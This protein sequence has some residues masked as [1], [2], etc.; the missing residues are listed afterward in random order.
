MLPSRSGPSPVSVRTDGSSRPAT[1]I[2][3][4][5]ADGTG[6]P[7]LSMPISTSRPSRT[8]VPRPSGAAVGVYRL[9]VPLPPPKRLWKESPTSS[10]SI[11][12]DGGR[13]S[14]RRYKEYIA[15]PPEQPHPQEKTAG[16]AV[17]LRNLALLTFILSMKDAGDALVRVA[18]SLGTGVPTIT[19]GMGTG[20]RDRLGLLRITVLPENNYYTSW[21]HPRM[22]R[23]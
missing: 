15:T 1:V 16:I 2:E 23:R 3:V 11:T 4:E 17:P 8:M 10:N 20:I 14:S 21:C 6:V 22:P 13:F 7:A 12:P 19:L 5:K 18:I 9:H